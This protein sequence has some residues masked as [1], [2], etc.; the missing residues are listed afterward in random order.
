MSIEN[1]IGHFNYGL[2]YYMINFNSF[3]EDG[4]S[5]GAF[6]TDGI[7]SQYGFTDRATADQISI[8]RKVYKL[9]QTKL[10]FNPANLKDTVTAE[11]IL[12]GRHFE[13][14]SCKLSYKAEYKEDEGV[15]LAVLAHRRNVTY[16]Y[17]T[18]FCE[19]DGE[20]VQIQKA[21]GFFEL[22]YTRL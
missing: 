17:F 10:N 18:G 6:M 19:V 3:T 7:G 15:N 2:A 21:W 8:D 4:K 9:D 20:E 14:N 16:G 13:T 12:E 11:T 1:Y 22:V 5:I